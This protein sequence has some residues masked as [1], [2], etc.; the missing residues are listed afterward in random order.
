MNHKGAATMAEG[1]PEL[2]MRSV[3]IALVGLGVVLLGAC[4]STPRLDASSSQAVGVAAELPAP[5][6]STVTYDFSKYRIGPLDMI[7]V[8]VFGA[9]ELTREGEVDAAGNFALPLVGSV[10][11]GGK[12]PNE[13]SEAIAAQLKGRYLKNPQVSVNVLKARGQSFTVDGSVRQPGVYPIVGRITL[14]QA[15][16]TAR[17]ADETANL[18]NVV[19]FRTVNNRKMAALFN[20]KEI[21]AGRLVDPDVYG[22]DIIVV[23]ENATRRF[24]KDLTSAFPSFGVFSP[25]L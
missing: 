22:N 2:H 13:L 3:E 12:T 14:Q 23:G 24:F 25:V 5:D 20:L 1:V 9:S 6:D 4:S 21:R 8:E 15:I 17:G 19:V 11:A 10:A 7:K 16:A 18:G